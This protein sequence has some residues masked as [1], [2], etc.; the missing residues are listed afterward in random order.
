[1]GGYV[2]RRVLSALPTGAYAFGDYCSGEVWIWNNSAA[3]LILN[4]A[5]NIVSFGED[6][7]GELYICY[8]N[9][10]IDEMVRATAPV[11]GRV[12]TPDG[13]GLRNASVVL[14]DSNGIARTVTT[15]SFGVYQFDGVATGQTVT[16]KVFSKLYRF[17]MQSLNVDGALTNID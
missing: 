8:S 6:E 3:E 4:T 13:R 10:Q 16:I 5:K 11:S 1:M 9:G 12:F 14:T 7:D 15:S 2:Y 17:T